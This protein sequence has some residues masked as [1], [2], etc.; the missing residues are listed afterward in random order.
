MA[1]MG[2]SS[3]PFTRREFV[4]SLAASAFAAPVALAAP[5]AALAAPPVGAQAQT[6]PIIK[7]KTLNHVGFFV[8]DV[9]RTAA[10]YQDLFGMPVQSRTGSSEVALRI[11]SGPQHLALIHALND[12]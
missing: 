11:G 3:Q 1:R 12:N 8:S 6:R 4:Q 9:R 7:P 10:W 5:L 2:Q